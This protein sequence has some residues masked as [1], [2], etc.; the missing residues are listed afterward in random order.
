MRG[1]SW[2]TS[3]LISHDRNR[4]ILKELTTTLTWQYDLWTSWQLI[5]LDSTI[6]ESNDNWSLNK[7]ITDLTWQCDP[8]T[9][10]YLISHDSTILESADYWSHLILRSLNQLTTDPHMIVRFLK[11]LIT[12][13][14]WQCDPWISWQLIYMILGSL[15]RL[16]TDLTW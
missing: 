16:I 2:N 13:V 4:T 5:S 15:N 3:Y 9:S 10:W 14:T 1:W 6:L 8:W 7:L 11:Q 12:D